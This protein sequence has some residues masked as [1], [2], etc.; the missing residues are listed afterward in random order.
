[1]RSLDVIGDSLKGVK[2]GHGMVQFTLGEVVMLGAGGEQEVLGASYYGGPGDGNGDRGLSPGY[3]SDDELTELA[4]S[5][6]RGEGEK[7]RGFQSS[8]G[9]GTQCH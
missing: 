3:A 2:L 1:M 4:E 8:N 9:L 6:V 7:R 5:T